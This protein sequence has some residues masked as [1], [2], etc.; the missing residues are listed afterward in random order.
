V[1]KQHLYYDYMGVTIWRNAKPGY[2]LR[3]SAIGY[4]ASDT[5]AGIKELIRGAKT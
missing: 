3:W 5:L 1:R 4:G 2:I